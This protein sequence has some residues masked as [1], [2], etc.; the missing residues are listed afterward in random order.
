M[1]RIRKLVKKLVQ[2]VSRK[3]NKIRLKI[4]NLTDREETMLKKMKLEAENVKQSSVS[5]I[6]VMDPGEEKEREQLKEKLRKDRD[7]I[8][9]LE[10]VMCKRVFSSSLSYSQLPGRHDRLLS[11]PLGTHVALLLLLSTI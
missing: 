7:I 2:I 6:I 3:W 11:A 5:F 1:S 9:R 10:E 4:I 8:E